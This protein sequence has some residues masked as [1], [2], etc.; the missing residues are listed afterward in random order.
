M[1]NVPT[2]QGKTRRRY[3]LE[4][5]QRAKRPLDVS[6]V[7]ALTS[8]WRTN[9][10]ERRGR[11][12][13]DFDHYPDAQLDV[14][15]LDVGRSLVREDVRPRRCSAESRPLDLLLNN[16]GR[17]GSAPADRQRRRIRTAVRH[18]LPR[19]FALT[20]QLLPALKGREGGTLCHHELERRR[21]GLLFVTTTCN[22][23]ATTFLS[24][25]RPIQTR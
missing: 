5:W 18:Q 24:R 10:R 16:A 19:P 11:E 12:T 3:W 4:Q 17:D 25:L 1:Y 2:Q 15:H 13:R 6:P 9:A 23:S 8:S 7:R 14:R 20:L 22:V 21:R